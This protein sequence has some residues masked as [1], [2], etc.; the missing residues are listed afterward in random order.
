MD[1]LGLVCES[2]RSTETISPQEVDLIQ[3][4]LPSNLNT[5]SPGVRQQTV[6][7]I[8]KVSSINTSAHMH[9]RTHACTHTHPSK[10]TANCTGSY[11]LFCLVLK[12]RPHHFTLLYF[13]M[14]STISCLL[15]LCMCLCVA[16]MSVKGQCSAASEKSKS[17]QRPS[18]EAD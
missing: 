14:A 11:T 3:H 7:L 10:F 2:H 5:Q 9:A 18:A 13:N 16:F 6:S 15:C 12:C 1:T 4:F 17:G 8:K